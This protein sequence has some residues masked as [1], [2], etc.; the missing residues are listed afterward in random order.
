[1]EKYTT[2]DVIRNADIESFSGL[3][4]EISLAPM[5]ATN[6]LPIDISRFGITFPDKNYRIKRNPS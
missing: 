6:L 1:M 5:P 4:K 3:G 2:F